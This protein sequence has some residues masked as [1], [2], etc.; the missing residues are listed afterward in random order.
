VLKTSLG[1]AL[2]FTSL[3]DAVEHAKAQ[4]RKQG[5][6]WLIEQEG[7]SGEV[8]R[9][10]IVNDAGELVRNDLPI[11][12]HQFVGDDV[13]C[14]GCL[15]PEIPGADLTCNECGTVVKTVP[16]DQVDDTLMELSLRQQSCIATCP[17]CGKEHVFPGFSSMFVF[18][19]RECGQVV[20]I[21]DG[22]DVDRIFG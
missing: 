1:S 18:T 15:Y 3:G 11:V 14:C 16:V 10:W 17:H 13:D 5:R 9:E 21:S 12:P 20:K 22:P 19:C 2:S 7:D 8:I 4:P 6:W